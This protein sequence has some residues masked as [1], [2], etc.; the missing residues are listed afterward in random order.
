MNV[1]SVSS[2]TTGNEIYFDCYLFTIE[3]TQGNWQQ[4]CAE[5]FHDVFMKWSRKD[6]KCHGDSVWQSVEN[7]SLEKWD[8]ASDDTKDWLTQ[9]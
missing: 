9:S 3:L 5:Q 6:G 4:I 8:K 2:A 7:I 1:K